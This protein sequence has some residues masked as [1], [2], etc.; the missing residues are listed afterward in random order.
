MEHSGES[1][2]SNLRGETALHKAV[3]FGNLEI[4]RLIVKNAGNINESSEVGDSQTPLKMAL[5]FDQPEIAELI[6]KSLDKDAELEEPFGTSP[7]HLAA[8]KGYFK[9]FQMIIK[10][11]NFYDKNPADEDDWTP[12]H[13]AAKN[14]HLDICQLIMKYV[15]EKN[16]KNKKGQTPYDLAAKEGHSKICEAISGN[17]GSK[18]DP[19][20]VDESNNSNSV[21]KRCK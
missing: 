18:I 17:K 21:K 1:N 15:K 12:L 2:P 7:L 3:G 9:V 19:N 4:C 5:E 20:D 10:R 6:V 8:E 13:Y 11:K 16:P 14:G